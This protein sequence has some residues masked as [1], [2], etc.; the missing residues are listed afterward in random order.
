[1]K[2]RGGV[3]SP[4]REVGMEPAIASRPASPN[5]QAH[6]RRLLK[7]GF[8]PAPDPP[9]AFRTRAARGRLPTVRSAT[10]PPSAPAGDASLAIKPAL[11]GWLCGNRK[12]PTLVSAIRSVV[13][14]ETIQKRVALSRGGPFRFQRWTPLTGGVKPGM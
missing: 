4:K 7:A 8:V 9:P 13:S 5:I 11:S 12:W 6:G 14:A 1:M 2:A 3:P 10:P